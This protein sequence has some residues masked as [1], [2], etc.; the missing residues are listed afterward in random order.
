MHDDITVSLQDTRSHII[1]G[2]SLRTAISVSIMSR[3]IEICKTIFC[4]MVRNRRWGW[5]EN[6][7]LVSPVVDMCRCTHDILEYWR[8]GHVY[9]SC[10]CFWKKQRQQHL[11]QDFLNVQHCCG[12]NTRW[13]LPLCCH[14]FLKW[15]HSRY[16]MRPLPAA[17]PQPEA[18]DCCCKWNTLY[19]ALDGVAHL[20]GSQTGKCILNTRETHVH[21][22]IPFD[23]TG[24][25]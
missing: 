15:K 10:L 4:P 12:T 19:A 25:H 6:E 21:L 23:R 11:L 2:S 24:L 1:N 14:P 18:F 16:Y 22:F 3:C 13:I 20:Y 8:T 9:G 17:A 7:N 5:N